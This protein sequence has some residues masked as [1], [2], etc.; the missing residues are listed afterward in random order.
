MKRVLERTPK[1]TIASFSL[2]ENFIAVENF[3]IFSAL[4]AILYSVSFRRKQ[5]VAGAWAKNDFSAILNSFGA[6]L[7]IIPK[8]NSLTFGIAI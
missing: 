1:G 4:F 2:L 3:A 8:T 5:S 6:A 7:G